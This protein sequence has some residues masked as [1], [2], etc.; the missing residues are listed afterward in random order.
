M[1]KERRLLSNSLFYK[2]LADEIVNPAPGHACSSTKS[3]INKNRLRMLSEKGRNTVGLSRPKAKR[4]SGEVAKGGMREG[5]NGEEGGSQEGFYNFS[6]HLLPCNSPQR[7][8]SDFLLK[9]NPRELLPHLC[10]QVS[11]KYAH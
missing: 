3:A 11:C 7:R 2:M 1:P 6:A 10:Q 5:R 9:K 8:A 4:E